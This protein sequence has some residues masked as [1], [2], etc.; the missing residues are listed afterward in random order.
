[1]EL[2][3]GTA[4]WRFEHLFEDQLCRFLGSRARIFA[5]IEAHMPGANDRVRLLASAAEFAHRWPALEPS[6]KRAIL[7]AHR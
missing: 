7:T 6:G 3:E 2:I 4:G 1:M 5:V